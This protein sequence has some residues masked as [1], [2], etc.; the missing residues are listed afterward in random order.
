MKSYIHIHLFSLHTVE[1]LL[2]IFSIYLH[3]TLT[4]GAAMNTES[5]CYGY[6]HQ[7]PQI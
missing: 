4:L 7:N 2:F 3:E 5:V 1:I 6:G